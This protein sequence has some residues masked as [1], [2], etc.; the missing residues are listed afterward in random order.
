MQVLAVPPLKIPTRQIKK[1]ILANPNSIIAQTKYMS[2]HVLYADT[3]THHTCR[4]MLLLQQTG[5]A[6][7][8]AHCPKPHAARE[9]TQKPH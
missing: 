8:I 7:K 6:N 5:P 9:H 1:V 3:T 2:H 4:L